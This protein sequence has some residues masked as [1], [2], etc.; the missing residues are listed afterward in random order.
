MPGSPVVKTLK[1]P[2]LRLS[3]RRSEV[4]ERKGREA[5]LAAARRSALE[6][7]EGQEGHGPDPRVTL[8][9]RGTDSRGEY[10]E[11][12]PHFRLPQGG[13]ELQ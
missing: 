12:E 3:G 8:R 2:R 11:A 7:K 6:G 5:D 13:Q 9:L 1:H 4:H 10:S